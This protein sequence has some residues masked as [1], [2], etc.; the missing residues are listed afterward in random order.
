MPPKACGTRRPWP[1]LP[2]RLHSC[3]LVAGRRPGCGCSMLEPGAL[4]TP[5]PADG[6][7]R[8]RCAG[9]AWRQA[10]AR[11]RGGRVLSGG[12]GGGGWVPS[13]PALAGLCTLQTPGT[14]PCPAEQ[15]GARAPLLEGCPGG[16]GAWVLLV[17][18]CTLTWVRYAGLPAAPL[19]GVAARP[20]S[21]GRLP[22]GSVM[23]SDKP[24]PAPR[25]H[26]PPAASKKQR[27]KEAYQRPEVLPPVEDPTTT[28][29]RGITRGERPPPPRPHAADLLCRP[30]L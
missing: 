2:S 14:G 17:C 24:R 12:Q 19:V 16:G 3:M 8:G 4:T 28:G 18:L 29:A 15:R 11:R 30:A 25:L 21:S 6:P 27:R 23:A 5:A 9:G 20:H 22:V 10:A 7:G 1:I 13:S 26:A